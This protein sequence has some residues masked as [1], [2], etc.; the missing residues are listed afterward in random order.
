MDTGIAVHVTNTVMVSLQ[1]RL[2]LAE[3]VCRFGRRLHGADK[4]DVGRRTG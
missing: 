3:D 2:Q 4:N 1:D